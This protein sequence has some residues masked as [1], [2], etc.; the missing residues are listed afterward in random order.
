[1]VDL[2]QLFRPLQ[3]MEQC[4]FGLQYIGCP[5]HI[6]LAKHVI[7]LANTSSDG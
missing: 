3:L 5:W 2:K 4:S 7:L 6:P 1:M